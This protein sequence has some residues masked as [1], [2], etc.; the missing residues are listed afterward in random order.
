MGVRN[1]RARHGAQRINVEIARRAKKTSGRWRKK[2]RRGHGHNIGMRA[3]KQRGEN[4][5]C[6]SQAFRDQWRMH[7]SGDLLADR[8]YGWALGACAD[9]DHVGA[10]DLLEQALERAP[11]W[12]PALVALGDSRAALHDRA[13]AIAAWEAGAKADPGGV[14]GAQLKLAATGAAPAPIAAPEDYVRALFDA[15]S[16]RFESHLVVALSYCG[17]QLLRAALER[18]CVRRARPFAFA[19]MIDLGCGTGLMAA[20]LRDVAPHAMGVDLS[21]RMVEAAA[22]TGLYDELHVGDGAAILRKEPAASAD[23]VIAA[24]VFVYIGD[25]AD[26][27]E[28]AAL[29]LNAGGLFA[30]SVQKTPVHWALGADLRYSHSETYL[31]ALAAGGGFDVVALEEASSRKDN[32]IDVPG[33]V[34]V[35]SRA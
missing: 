4:G 34:C 1:Q 2:M 28:Q 3:R 16:E 21:P 15:Y 32:G 18:A 5:A 19:R 10:C 23:L 35:L 22:R 25:L 20:A 17:P 12:A 29:V 26:M 31:R 24:D 27:F 11:G 7:S 13:G 33:L 14:H 6:A 9:G 8:R 30:F